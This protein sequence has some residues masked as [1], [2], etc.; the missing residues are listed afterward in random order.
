MER[1]LLNQLAQWKSRPDRK[2]LIIFGARQV[3]KSYLVHQFGKQHFQKI[4]SFNF[5][6]NASL[7]QFFEQEIQPQAILSYLEL[8][9]QERIEAGKT[10]IF[11]DEVQACPRALTS[12]KYFCE[13]APQYHLVAAGSLLGVALKREQHSFPV[14]KVQELQL[15]PMDFEE[16]LWARGNKALAQMIREHY[17]SNEAM[18]LPIHQLCLDEYMSYCVIGGMPE[19]V[20]KFESSKSYLEVQEI[21]HNILNEYI[22]DM[23]KYASPATSVK[24]RACFNSIPA[25]L[26]KNN[27]KFQYKV[28]KRGGNAALFGEAIDWLCDAGICL[29]CTSVTHAELPLKGYY[30]LGNFKLYMGDIGLLVQHS[31][32]PIQSILSPMAQGHSFMGALAENY[33]AQALRSNGIPLTYW[34][35]DGKAEVDYIMQQG[36]Q[37][38]P[39]E[40]KA[41]TDV[42]S[43]SLSVIMQRYHCEYAIR[44]SQKNFGLQGQIKAVPLYAAFA[45]GSN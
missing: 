32:M 45:I 25:Q 13:L 22:A 31:G 24:I 26:A 37:I 14:G 16:F 8:I 41:G 10:L 12:L 36:E 43:R 9:S 2:P 29:K 23:A 33:I 4:L 35:S 28:V 7:C 6:T 40:V 18:P 27:S 30:E 38:V 34:C 42:R 20:K 17:Q 11:F 21:Q 44:L 19:A 1:K 5:E 39:I 3:G 15:Y